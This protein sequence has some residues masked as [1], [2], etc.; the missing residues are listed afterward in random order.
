MIKNI[1][2]DLGNIVIQNPNIDTILHFTENKEKAEKLRKAIFGSAEWKLLDKGMITYKEATQKIQERNIEDKNLI[3]KIMGEWFEYQP[4]NEETVKIAKNLKEKGHR[5]YVLSN[6]A[7]ETYAHFQ[8]LSFFQ[9]CNGIMISA[10][11]HMVKPDKEIFIRLL[12]KYALKAEECLFI[13]DDDTYRSIEVANKIGILGRRVE[14]N[15]P[16]DIIKLLEEFE[17][18]I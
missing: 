18:K 6:M 1:I 11:E 15:N 12:D 9:Y 8:E 4:I 10:Q 5:I 3:G 17:I 2:F 14:P 16:Q 13:D 7:I